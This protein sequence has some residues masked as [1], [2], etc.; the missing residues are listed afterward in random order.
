M[1]RAEDE[2]H[3][4]VQMTYVSENGSGKYGFEYQKDEDGKLTLLQ[5]GEKVT[6]DNLVNQVQ[7]D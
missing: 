7:T 2:K 1:V 5:Q 3:I 4:V 6:I